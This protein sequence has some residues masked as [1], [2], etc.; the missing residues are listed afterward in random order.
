M[1]SGEIEADESYFGEAHGR[2]NETEVLGEKV[3]VFGL[4]KLGG[5]AYTQIIKDATSRT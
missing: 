1:F 3:S 2:E 5:K 4:L